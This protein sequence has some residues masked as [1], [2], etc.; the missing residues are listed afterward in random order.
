ML[1]VTVTLGIFTKC[2]QV[3]FRNVN[4]AT[5]FLAAFTTGDAQTLTTLPQ[6]LTADAQFLCQFGFAHLILV[7]QHKML[8]IVF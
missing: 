6:T 5:F 1:G 3:L 4:S 8:E 2:Y 7:F